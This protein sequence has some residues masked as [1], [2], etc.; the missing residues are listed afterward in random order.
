[1]L[2]RSVRSLRRLSLTAAPVLLLP[3]CASMPG[4][5]EWLW[6]GL[7]VL[8]MF[9]GAKLPSL[10][11]SMGSGINEFKKGLKEGESD[12][13]KKLDGDGDSKGDAKP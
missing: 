4:G 1:M 9:G 2:N 13:A 10:M 6:I 12:D 7:V 8:L 11:R 5:N 3:A